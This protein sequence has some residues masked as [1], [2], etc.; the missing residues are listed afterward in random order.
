[1][2]HVDVVDAILSLQQLNRLL[3]G[4]VIG[5]R[6]DD[7]DDFR[8]LAGRESFEPLLRFGQ[9]TDGRDDRHIVLLDVVGLRRWFASNFSGS[10][11]LVRGERT[12]RPR[13]MPR[14]VP[15]MR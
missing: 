2:P 12:T 5:R 3:G 9:I 8:A 6:H 13:P 15:V 10:A 1:M 7:H 11:S 4:L 14:D